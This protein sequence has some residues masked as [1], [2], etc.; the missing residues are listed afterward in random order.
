M[1]KIID[2]RVPSDETAAIAAEMRRSEDLCFKIN[3]THPQSEEYRNLVKELFSGGFGENSRI[4]P[5]VNI[6]MGDR[7]HIGKNVVIGYNLTC[8]SVGGINIEDN[9]QIAAN[10]QLITN[11]HDMEDRAILIAEPITLKQ[12]AWIGAGVTILPGVTVGE[13]AVIAAGAVVSKDVED[14]TVVGGVP[15]KVIKKLK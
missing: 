8:M 4:R 11:N 6:L 1:K 14:N 2:M 15:A 9:V 13:N 5:H 12:G 3:T 7:I 10:V